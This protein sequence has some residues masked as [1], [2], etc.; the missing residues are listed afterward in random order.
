MR[1]QNHFGLFPESRNNNFYRHGQM[2][3]KAKLERFLWWDSEHQI[4]I[5]YTWSQAKLLEKNGSSYSG[6]QCLRWVIMRATPNVAERPLIY[7]V[8]GWG[9][10]LGGSESRGWRL[11]SSWYKQVMLLKVSS[12]FCVH[13]A[14][15]RVI[16]FSILSH[17]HDVLPKY[18]RPRHNGSTPWS[19]TTVFVFQS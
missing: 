6:G 13:F 3:W 11:G 15:M 19:L 18:M 14:T 8:A 7:S 5:T 9:I 17:C 10:I 1:R 12:P 16:T 2:S 4:N